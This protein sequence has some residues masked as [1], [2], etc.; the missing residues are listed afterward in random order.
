VPEALQASSSNPAFDRWVRRSADDLAMLTAETPY[1]PFPFA[2]VP[3]F[4]TP[5]GR[6]ALITAYSVLWLDP[7]LARGVLRFLAAH[8]A[9][10]ASAAADAEPG[11]IFHE[12]RGGEMPALGEVPFGCYYGSVDVTP[13][14]VLLAAAYYERTGEEA[15][16]RELWPSLLAALAWIDGPGDPDGDGFV[17]YA[18]RAGGGLAN[19]GWKDS[20]DSIMHADGTPAAGPIALCEV[21]AY[22]YA[23]KSGLARVARALGEGALAGRLAREAADLR[24]R[25]ARAFWCEELGTFALALDGGKRPCRVP[26]SNAGHALFAGIAL[27]EHAARVAESLLS[28]DLFSGWGVR[29]LGASAARFNPMSYHNGSVWP[30]DNALVAQGLA[31]YGA[32]AGAERIFAAL[33]DASLAMDDARLPEL[34][35]GF[36]RVDGEQPALYPVACSPQAW[37]AASVFLL[38]QTALGVA[39]DARGRRVRAVRPAL[40]A[41]LE[42]VA[43]RGIA[44]GDAVLDVACE[45]SGEESRLRVLR[46]R[47]EVELAVTR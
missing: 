28:R 16:L 9:Q 38:L 20:D 27:P 25:F 45:R 24:E 33:F 14:F 35:C 36:D 5:F 29:T 40:P 37:S 41:F 26:S 8:Q 17:E 32:R 22:V 23:A 6:D 15:L 30:H 21:Q 39:I 10:G 42:R 11:K 43:L 1:G 12:L 13:W 18:R 19:Q 4:A 3:W 47:G 44:V 46:Q 34:V 7:G 2:G 31:R